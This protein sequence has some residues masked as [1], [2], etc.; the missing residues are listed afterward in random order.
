[1]VRAAKRIHI[2]NLDPKF[3]RDRN[4]DGNWVVKQ[5]N[6]NVSMLDELVGNLPRSLP[7]H[8][9][10]VEQLKAETNRLYDLGRP[11][12]AYRL[13]WQDILDQVQA[14]GLLSTWRLTELVSSAVWA[15]RRNDPL[16]AA[17]VARAALETSASYAWFQSKVRPSI[18]D[19]IGKD[20]IV[21]FEQLEDEIL[22]TLWASRL[23]ETGDFYN[24][25]N[26]VTIIGH[27]TRKV[28]NQ[29][30][31]KAYYDVLCEVAHPNFLGRSIFLS[32]QEGTTVISRIRGPTAAI[33]EQA[34]LFAL[35]WAAGTLPLSLT[36]MQATCVRMMRDL[37]RI[38]EKVSP[39]WTLLQSGKLDKDANTGNP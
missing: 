32:E 18:D 36:P 35:S 21:A 16:C 19:V 13:A 6:E 8:P 2:P 17:I 34:S 14:F 11:L 23:E 33:V 37:D 4:P 39:D 5:F 28:P 22:K 9:R 24:P 3:V 30:D 12:D 20:Q 27:I 7:W 15:I 31:V 38:S 1:M 26:I 25:T 10:T 29:G